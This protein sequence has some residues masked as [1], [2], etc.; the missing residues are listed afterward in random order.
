MCSLTHGVIISGDILF[1][2]WSCTTVSYATLPWPFEFVI[3]I[4]LGNFSEYEILA[5]DQFGGRFP[6]WLSTF[7]VSTL[8]PEPI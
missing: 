8:Q 5:L 7:I 6:K 4:G 2:L 3:H 1:L